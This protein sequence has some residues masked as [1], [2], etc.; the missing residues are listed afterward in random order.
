VA[1]YAG[2]VKAESAGKALSGDLAL[3]F[4]LF[5][6]VLGLV[7]PLLISAFGVKKLG[8]TAH[9]G[10]A[11]QAAAGNASSVALEEERGLVNVLLLSDAL[12]VLGGFVLR[13]IVIFAALPI[14][15]G[16]II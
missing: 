9:A 8:K 6:V 3:W 1:N 11:L 7:V 14:W 15:N 2:G 12:V 13:Y 16:T 4:W 10:H 5:L